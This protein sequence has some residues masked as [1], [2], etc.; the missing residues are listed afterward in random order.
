[1]EIF[2]KAASPRTQSGFHPKSGPGEK[3][4]AWPN[5]ADPGMEEAKNVPWDWNL[6]PFLTIIARTDLVGYRR[7]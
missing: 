7:A 6:T 4:P 3:T 5:A 1:M 2:A